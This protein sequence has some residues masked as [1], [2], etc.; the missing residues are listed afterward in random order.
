MFRVTVYKNLFI[1]LFVLVFSATGSAQVDEELYNSKPKYLKKAGKKSMK[2]G[3]YY[4][5]I[6]YFKKYLKS[7]PEKAKVRYYLADSYR[8]SRDYTKAQETYTQVVKEDGEGYP[9]AYY[10]LAK[11]QIH[12]QEYDDAIASFIKFKKLYQ[13]KDKNIYKKRV[14]LLLLTCEGAPEML[15]KKSDINVVH[16][17]ASINKAHIESAPLMLDE[18]TLVYSS[19]RSDTIVYYDA[20]DT[21]KKYP[22]RQ[23]YKAKKDE[24]GIWA[25]D[26]IHY[27]ALNDS[28]SQNS[29]A[30]FNLDSTSMFFSRCAMN[31]KGKMICAIYESKKEQGEW[32]KPNK[33][34]EAINSPDYSS[35]QPTVGRGDKYGAE[36]LYF[37]SDNPKNKGGLDIWYSEF[38]PKKEEWNKS[39]NAGSS[40]NTVL[41]EMTPWYDHENKTMYFSTEGWPGIGGLDVFS[42]TGK[43]KNWETPKNIGQPINSSTDD[44]YYIQSKKGGEGFFVSNRKGGIT[45]KNE[46]C[47]DDIYEYKEPKYIHLAINGE[48][49]DIY[50]NVNNADSAV[51]L[52]NATLSLYAV[53]DST[54][55]EFLIK[56]VFSNDVGVYFLK[57]Q[58]EKNYL[59]KAQHPQT[60]SDSYEFSTIGAVVSDTLKKDFSLRHITEKPIVIKNIYYEFDKA[61]LTESSKIT[62]DTTLLDI[63][64]QNKD[65]IIEI[66][67]HTDS[68][69]SDIYNESLSQRRAESVVKYL[70]G[71]GVDKARL[72]AK[73]YG[74][75]KFLVPNENPDG[76]DSE[77]GRALNRRTEF[78]IVGKL[79]GVSEIIY[80]R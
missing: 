73:G 44:L 69:G 76:T 32:Q 67:S 30:C 46:T 29:N 47:C 61:G 75:T 18:N 64:E 68:K 48:L 22:V 41:D 51:V 63:L 80:T 34:P 9:K 14:K 6:E 23:F 10:Y 45:L 59:L 26:N 79:E 8:L 40:I 11:M 24:K 31:K 20:N 66:G 7:K 77:E 71:K 72:Q 38:R 62:I 13:E 27:K 33:L 19:L 21:T 58:K 2:R 70:I 16:L 53:N 25:F 15:S 55:E 17:D 57:L 43:L 49:F 3:D 65:I 42:T 36:V 39:K 35:S 54:K 28:S 12:N 37:V 50:S 74:E 1:I 60:L 56:Q 78:R 5:A 4:G 52:R